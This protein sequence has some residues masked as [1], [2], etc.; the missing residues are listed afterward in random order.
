MWYYA[1]VSILDQKSG[2]K[3][4]ILRR[5]VARALIGRGGGCIFIYSCSP[6]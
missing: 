3:G 6:D 4:V 2:K 1:L 5:A